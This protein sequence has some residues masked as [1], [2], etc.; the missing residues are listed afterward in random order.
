[1]RTAAEPAR[2]LTIA[3]RSSRINQRS[4]SRWCVNRGGIT[5]T[6]APV[7]SSTSER[8][9]GVGIDG[10]TAL[11]SHLFDHV[12]QTDGP[13]PVDG[14][15]PSDVGVSPQVR[16][17]RSE[18][19]RVVRAWRPGGRRHGVRT[20]LRGRVRCQSGAITPRESRRASRVESA[21]EMSAKVP[22]DI[23]THGWSRGVRRLSF[24]RSEGGPSPLR[25]L[26]TALPS[27]SVNTLR[28]GVGTSTLLG[29]FSIGSPSWSGDRGLFFRRA[30]GPPFSVCGSSLQ[31]SLPTM[32]GL[33]P[34][35]R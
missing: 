11:T 20:R 4:S 21:I 5:T 14:G 28:S 10:A 35:R 33:D 24:P 15:G 30:I 7:A 32:L 31:E 23:R 13:K 18:R 22:S 6:D 9:S 8:E 34:T 17:L 19:Y 12:V 26:A 25:S 16:L 3:G 29:V 2:S 27:T 1:M